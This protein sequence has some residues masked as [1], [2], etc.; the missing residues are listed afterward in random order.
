MTK[1]QAEM[2]TSIALDLVQATDSVKKLTTAVQSSQNAWKAQEAA[3]KSSGDYLKAAEA[4]YEGLG[5]TIEVQKSKLNALKSEQSELKGSTA[6]VAAQYL[7]YQKQIDAATTQLSS[8]ES[9]QQRAKS[10]MDYQKSGLAG[11]QGEYKRMNSVTESYVKRLQAEGKEEEA[12]KARLSGLKSSIGNLNEQYTKQSAELQRIAETSGKTSDAYSRQ[13]VRVNETATAMAKAKSEAG[14]LESTLNKS[15]GGGFFSS[16]KEKLTGVRKAENDTEKSTGK[17]SSAFKGGLLGGAIGG[18]VS[19]GISTLVGGLQGMATS[20]Y[21]A[22]EA[23]VEM[24]EKWKNI[25]VSSAGVKQLGATVKD[26]KENTQLS[27]EAAGNLVTRF[28]S[29]TGSVKQAQDLA[30]GVGS[31]A[32][33]LKLSQK[34][35]E[36]FSN[37]LTRIESTGTVTASGLGRLEKQAP[38]LGAA[39]AKAAD[40][41]QAK[42]EALVSTGKVTSTQFNGWLK[43]ASKSYKENSSEF[44]NSSQ[45]AM[46]HIKQSWA[47]TK[48]SLMTPLVSVAGS[49]LGELG[50][51]IDSKAVQSGV[52]A[53]GKGLANVAKWLS[54]LISGVAKVAPAFSGAFK[55]VGTVVS[56]ALKSIGSIWHGLFKSL[57]AM[58]LSKKVNASGLNKVFSGFNKALSSGISKAQPAFTA[59]G[60]VVGSVYKAM[61]PL[62]KAVGSYTKSVLSADSAIAKGVWSV[63]SKQLKPVEK[64]FSSLGKK[65]GVV[66][67]LG[68]MLTSV[69][70]VVKQ[71]DP[72]WK[73]LGKIVGT[74]LGLAFRVLAA[75]I[76]VAASAITLIVKGLTLLIKGLSTVLKSLPGFIKNM[77]NGFSKMS[78]GVGKTLS[79]LWD[80]TKKGWSSMTSNVSKTVDKGGNDIS[81]SWSSFWGSTKKNWTGFWSQVGKNGSN[82]MSSLRTI[83]SGANDKIS[84]GWKKMWSSLGDWFGGIWKGIKSAARSGLNGVIDIIN[85]AISGINWVW[86]KFTGKNALSKLQK[87]ANGGV[88]GTMRMVMVNDAPGNDYKE[89]FQTPNGQVGM[90]QDRNAVM[91]LPEGTRVYNGQ[92]TKQIMSMAGIKHYASGGIVGAIE[93]KLSDIEDWV[94][95]PLKSVTKM[96]SKFTS[97]ISSTTSMFTDLG[98]GV[99]GKL[100]GSIA[101]WFKK[102]LQTVEDKLELSN[103]GGASVER[104]RPYVE[105][106]LKANGFAA[107]A[108][109]ISAWMAVI[110]RESNGN[111]KAINLWD[112][113]AKAGIPSMGLVQTIKPTFEAYKFKGHDNIYN[114]YDDLLAGINYM[115]HRYGRSASAFAR[116]SGPEGYANGGIITSPI[117]AIVGEAGDEAIL[118][119][120]ASRSSRAWQLL[121]QAMNRINKNQGTSD[122]SDSEGAALSAKLESVIALLSKLGGAQVDLLQQI[123]DKDTSIDGKTLTKA[124]TPRMSVQQTKRQV[125]TNRGVAVDS[126]L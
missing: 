40:M 33:N 78:K 75:A 88:V 17:L 92:Q 83:V 23:G 6:D 62:V 64:S 91:A 108:S 13:K 58:D 57:P 35:A 53:L 48:Q 84:S 12:N 31:I 8:L 97:G 126:Q 107:S 59:F 94:S 22:A 7:K 52:S 3:L 1:I 46:K 77:G 124:V 68:K 37:G 95:N 66:D 19:S 79:D 55:I 96:L 4:R 47:D 63:L 10:T 87:L 42:F 72:L 26:L 105:K 27:G 90:A 112:S 80:K 28:Y 119:L 113:N 123:A 71:L 45:G 122:A 98:K 56:G 100:T 86:K 24:Q 20:G 106:A 25:G 125:L 89:L 85:G 61:V 21:K 118:P 102:G 18:A 5:K 11:L 73:V 103:P 74:T 114:G 121:G 44:D 50:K 120:S 81:K 14:N 32:D 51:V 15:T 16:V 117:H 2:S 69:G 41:P 9:Q 93:D 70:K 115:A 101:D 54:Q 60:K 67:A 110:K 109:Q 65:G 43:T 34:G 76:K 38:G 111:P 39:L 104:W 116:V 30:K 36:S 99:V 49:G 82:G 29:T